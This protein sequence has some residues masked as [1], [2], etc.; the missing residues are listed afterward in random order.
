MVCN[1]L[2]CFCDNADL[3]LQS[4]A[5]IAPESRM[6]LSDEVCAVSLT[7]RTLL[8]PSPPFLPPTT[9]PPLS[10][11][12][13][14]ALPPLTTGSDLPPLGPCSPPVVWGPRWPR[15][16]GA[17][18]LVRPATGSGSV[19]APR[20]S[21]REA[22][23]GS[24]TL[25]RGHSSWFCTAATS[26]WCEG[27][28]GRNAGRC[29]HRMFERRRAYEKGRRESPG[30][31]EAGHGA[32]CRLLPLLSAHPPPPLVQSE[33]EGQN[34]GR[35]DWKYD[36]EGQKDRWSKKKKG[37]MTNVNSRKLEQ[38]EET[39]SAMFVDALI[40]VLCDPCWSTGGRLEDREK[41]GGTGDET[42]RENPHLQSQIL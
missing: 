17:K 6:Q 23:G 22:T 25:A 33:E 37:R 26:S 30:L 38:S 28:E 2:H 5:L 35:E 31:N 39:W 40:S 18:E 41:R 15:R 27:E 20:A 12:T 29:R 8:T 11:P 13:P 10:P 21:P 16:R 32:Q 3:S 4:A 24:R 7:P 1:H 36:T 34:K 42:R 14:P 19:A 9:P